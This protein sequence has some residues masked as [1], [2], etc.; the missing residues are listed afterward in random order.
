RCRRY[1]NTGAREG[2]SISAALFLK[3]FVEKTPWAHIDLAGPVWSEKDG[4]YTA[5]GAT[6]Y[7]VR[8]LVDWVM[9]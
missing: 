4:A 9:A 1:E 6:G 5:K 2:G 3:R 7:G 8:L